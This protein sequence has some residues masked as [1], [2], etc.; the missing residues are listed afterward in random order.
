MHK[1]LVFGLKVC[2]ELSCPQLPAASFYEPDVKIR[3]G[4]VPEILEDRIHSR[5]RFD[6]SATATLLRIPEVGRFLIADG[7]R[8][9][10]EPE[11]SAEPGVVRLFLLGSSLGAVLHQRGIM[12]LHG[13]AVSHES[14]AIVICGDSGAGKSTTA[15]V[16]ASR[17]YSILTDDITALW[18]KNG[19]GFK[20]GKVMLAPGYPQMKLWQNTLQHLHIRHQDHERVRPGK[21]KHM[22][23]I[24]D[25]FE[26]EPKAVHALFWLAKQPVDAPAI[27]PLTG[28]A[29]FNAVYRNVYRKAYVAALSPQRYFS[30]C[31]QIARHLSVFSLARPELDNSIEAV[32]DLIEV[33]S[34]KK[35]SA[36]GRVQTF[37]SNHKFHILT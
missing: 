18:F 33:H 32:A 5:P 27:Q 23:Q 17:G 13:S 7:R 1:Y 20:K 8:I 36:P 15:A 22:V 26:T 10:V 28:S 12:P 16:L 37:L 2:S 29:R 14:G 34:L 4:S 21:D 9:V 11:S 35:Q 31:Q 30:Q 19:E 25:S 24:T 3:F 6:V